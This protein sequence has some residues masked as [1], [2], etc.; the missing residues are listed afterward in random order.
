MSEY[1]L[2]TRKDVEYIQHK[3]GTVFY[4]TKKH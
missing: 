4:L 1:T 2:I 3:K